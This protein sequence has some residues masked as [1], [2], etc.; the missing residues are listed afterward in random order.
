MTS[1]ATVFDDHPVTFTLFRGE[2]VV[3][4]REIGAAMGYAGRGLQDLIGGPWSGDFEE[5]KDYHLL[6]GEA[7]AEFK[8]VSRDSSGFAGR[9]DRSPSLLLLTETGLYAVALKTDKALG[10]RLR[11]F[12]AREVLPKLARGE[13]V[14][15]APKLKHEE[16]AEARE[17]RI[18]ADRLRRTDPA[19]AHALYAKACAVLGVEAPVGDPP[20]LGGDPKMAELLAAWHA[21]FSDRPVTSAEIMAFAREASPRSNPLRD[22]LGLLVWKGRTPDPLRLGFFLRELRGK[23]QGAFV[24]ARCPEMRHGATLWRCDRVAQDRAP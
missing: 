24:I 10:V 2:P 22:A 13:A 4:A 8:A 1:I 5:G 20:K 23:Q 6:T 7:L 17:Y 14:G 18:L 3:P 11:R 16:R 19:R 9:V 12:L 21:A 15:S